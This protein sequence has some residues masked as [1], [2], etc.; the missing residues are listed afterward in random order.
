MKKEI[1]ITPIK[2]G[3][4][5]DHLQTGSAKKII[6]IL[7]LEGFTVTA[8]M[9][10]ESRKMGKKDI[11]FID[12]KEL[13]GKELDKVALIGKGATVNI[14]RNGEI[15]KKSQL[16]YPENVEEIIRCINPKC[17]TNYE[18][19]ATKFS[20]RKEPLDAKCF[21]CETR[22]NAHEIVESMKK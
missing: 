19:L 9:N 2:N 12:G 3:T 17:I 13:S 20:I 11:M 15:V 22:M 16:A 7:D 1:R 21:Y 14:I 10:V 6:E 18:R 4:A 5:I 8:G